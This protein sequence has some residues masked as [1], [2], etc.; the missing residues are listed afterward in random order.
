MR[1][2]DP[3]TGRVLLA[4]LLGRLPPPGRLQRAS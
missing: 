4:E 1:P 3:G 2:L